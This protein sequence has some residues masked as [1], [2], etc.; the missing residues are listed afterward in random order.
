MKPSFALILGA[1]AAATLAACGQPGPLYMPTP[2]AKPVPAATAPAPT[3][4]A[5]TPSSSP[6][7]TQQ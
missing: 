2:P 5:G 4:A 3:P 6:L 1:A 7:P